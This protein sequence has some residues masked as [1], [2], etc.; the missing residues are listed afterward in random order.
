[1]QSFPRLG[2][3]SRVGT[4]NPKTWDDSS[5]RVSMYCRSLK[6]FAK[7][8]PKDSL[9]LNKSKLTGNVNVFKMVLPLEVYQILS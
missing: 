6:I 1:M 2:V 4:I 7:I 8:D 9:E 3:L 5:T